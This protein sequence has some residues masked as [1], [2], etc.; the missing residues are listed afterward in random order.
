MIRRVK[1]QRAHQ[2]DVVGVE[3]R[4]LSGNELNVLLISAMHFSGVLILWDS[5]SLKDIKPC[6]I[7]FSPS[8][9]RFFIAK[10]PLP[11]KHTVAVK[12]ARILPQIIQ[13]VRTLSRAFPFRRDIPV[14]VLC[15]RH[16]VIRPRFFML[17]KLFRRRVLRQR[18][19]RI[20][21]IEY[22]RLIA[23]PFSPPSLIPKLAQTAHFKS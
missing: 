21:D 8:N 2:V 14:H 17:C 7:F 3:L 22:D 18:I 12:Y 20:L 15:S 19:R 1:V 23:Y 9:I 16:V 6:Q 5:S 10:N 11:P 4:C 13:C